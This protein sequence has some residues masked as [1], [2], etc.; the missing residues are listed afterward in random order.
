[1]ITDIKTGH[2]Y[3]L[4]NGQIICIDR[5]NKNQ[6]F[7][8]NNEQDYNHF[9]SYNVYTE[10]SVANAANKTDFI[11]L[12]NVKLNGK[13]LYLYPNEIKLLKLAEI[14]APLLRNG[15][16]IRVHEKI[17]DYQ[18][19]LTRKYND[20]LIE[21]LIAE[22]ERRHRFQNQKRTSHFWHRKKP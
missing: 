14:K 2:L 7:F 13:L 20:D 15:I 4:H 3:F 18:E 19:T 17:F 16:H 21:W 1:M 10:D 5:M 22:D 9:L 12:Q 8:A 11:L 6:M